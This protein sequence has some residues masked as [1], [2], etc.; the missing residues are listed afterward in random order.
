MKFV[1]YIFLIVFL[2]FFGTLRGQDLHF[3]YYEMSPLTLNPALTGA[4]EGTFRVGGIYRDQWASVIS[5]PFRTPSFY[6]DAP[7][8]RGFGK[9][10]WVGVGAVVFSDQAGKANLSNSAL[11]ASVAYHM[12]L[13][14]KSKNVFTLGVQGGVIQRRIDLADAK[15]EDELIAGGNFQ[16]TDRNNINDNTSYV[17]FSVGAMLKSMIN[18][19]TNLTLGLAFNHITTPNNSLIPSDENRVESFPDSVSI[20]DPLNIV[21]HGLLNTDLSAKWMLSP[22][23]FWQNKAGANEIMVQTQLG[24]YLNEKKDIKLNFGLGYRFG[25]AG[26]ALVGMDYKN[27]RVGASYDINLSSLT[28]V[29]NSVGGFEIA[30]S[31]IAKIFKTPKV[32]PVILCPR[33]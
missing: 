33:F 26:L 12:S 2:N 16:S 32:K 3:T 30:V 23:I 27:L 22:G 6:V 20:D 18:K 1:K 5:N 4:F 17:D 19:K 7:I 15:F 24:Y 8:I 14:K 13:D 9:R 31:Y 10:D 21:F 11:L 29:S 28:E 25:D